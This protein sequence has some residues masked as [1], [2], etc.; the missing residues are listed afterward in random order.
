MRKL[1]DLPGQQ[2]FQYLDDDGKLCE[3]TSQDVNDYLREITG[4]D[5]T[6][7]DFRTWAG[8]VLT[9]M[10]LNAQGKFESK[11]E[12]AMSVKAAIAAAAKLLAQHTDDL[13]EMLCSSGGFGIVPQRPPN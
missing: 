7:K 13:P 11:K 1:Q 6:A 2:L 5:F 8:T 9:A 3:V 4:E 12:A 10:A